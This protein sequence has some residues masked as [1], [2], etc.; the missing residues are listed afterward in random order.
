MKTAKSPNSYSTHIHST[1]KSRI[2]EVKLLCPGSAK[3][4]EKE[5]L[6]E[7]NPVLELREINTKPAMFLNG[8]NFPFLSFYFTFIFK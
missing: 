7:K 6:G 2:V 3:E 8:I 5:E 4:M 1:I